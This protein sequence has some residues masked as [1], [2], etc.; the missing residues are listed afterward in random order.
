[1]ALTGR[2]HIA[3]PLLAQVHHD[4]LVMLR[5]DD[6]LLEVEDDLGHVLLDA[7]DRGEL[8]EDV[9][10]PDA[11]D[12]RTGDA[13]QERPAQGVPQGVA[14]ARL[15]GLQDEPRTVVA[16]ALLSEGRTLGNKHGLPFLSVA[17]TI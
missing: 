1:L 4:R 7:R 5:G 16:D 3:G 14:E 17:T 8:V 11:G 12:G 10:D 9:L 13:R 6:E 15:E 2:G